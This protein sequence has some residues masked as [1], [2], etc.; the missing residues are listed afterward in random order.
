M[1][2]TEDNVLYD[3][4][5]IEKNM[6]NRVKINTDLHTHINDFASINNIQISNED[7]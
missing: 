1:V 7:E 3:N 6:E 5:S 4:P 2:S